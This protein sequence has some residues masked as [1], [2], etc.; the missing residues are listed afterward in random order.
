MGLVLVTVPLQAQI[1]EQG[2]LREVWT[3]IGGTAVSAL[4]NDPDYPDN[5]SSANF[6]TDF[7][8]APINILNGS[9]TVGPAVG[10][11]IGWVWRDK[12]NGTFML[13]PT[14]MLFLAELAE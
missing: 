8:E 7:F 1:P 5:P 2:L 9:S 13:Y 14:D 10:P 12:G 6:V 11:D 3:G 4:T